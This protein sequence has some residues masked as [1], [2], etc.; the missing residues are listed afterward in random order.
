MAYSGVEHM[1]IVMLGMAA[2]GI[3]YYAAILHLVSAF[4]CQTGAFLSVRA[5]LQDL[6]QQKCL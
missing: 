5:D 4:L 6:W 3:G 1:G 2:G